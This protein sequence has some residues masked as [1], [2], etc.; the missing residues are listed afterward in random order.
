MIEGRSQRGD[1]IDEHH[2]IGAFPIKYHK[3][4]SLSYE[5]ILKNKVCWQIM[6]LIVNKLQSNV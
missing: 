1:R 4:D 5:K 2:I 6:R 3:Q